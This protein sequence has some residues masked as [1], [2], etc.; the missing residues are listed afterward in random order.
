MNSLHSEISSQSN[1]PGGS[2]LGFV[3]GVLFISPSGWGGVVRMAG[4]YKNVVK[5]GCKMIGKVLRIDLSEKQSATI[6]EP[7][8][9]WS[10]RQSGGWL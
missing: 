1:G 10:V 4:D 6:C 2:F 9:L 8:I 7:F 3:Y 5:N